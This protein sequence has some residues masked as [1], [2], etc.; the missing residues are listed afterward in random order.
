MGIASQQA[1]VPWIIFRP[2]L[3]PSA[4]PSIITGPGFP[5]PTSLEKRQ[6]L[7][8][9]DRYGSYQQ[10][11][12]PQPGRRAGSSR[13]SHQV[14]QA[15]VPAKKKEFL[16]Y[17]L[18]QDVQAGCFVQLLGQVVKDNNWHSDKST[19][20]I[21]DYTTNESL[22]DYEHDLD[23]GTVGDE[24]SYLSRKRKDWPGPWGKLTMQV[25]LWEPHASFA[26][27]RVKPGDLVLLTYV[28][29]KLGSTG[30]LEAAVHG[31][32]RYPHRVHIR[33]VSTEY[34]ERARDLMARRKEYWKIHGKPK[35]QTKETKKQKKMEE[36]KQEE[37]KDESRR[38]LRTTSSRKKLNAYGKST[39]TGGK[40]IETI[41]LL[42]IL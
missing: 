13:Q 11:T 15:S 26:R 32:K 42:L 9:L 4:G 28:H 17:T 1:R 24:Y 36:K 33:S 16:P 18:I 37:R 3:D 6:A 7:A 14:V 38:K 25:T 40:Q 22:V 35:E 12:A 27:E 5:P 39:F 20:W 21:T 2:E 23:S 41:R 30:N 19:I 8:L 10:L 34:D 31:D 29:I